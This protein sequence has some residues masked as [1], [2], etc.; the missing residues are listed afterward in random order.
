MVVNSLHEISRKIIT[1]SH[2]LLKLLIVL[3]FL[4][5]FLLYVID[6]SS[7]VVPQ[8]LKIHFPLIGNAPPPD[9]AWNWDFLREYDESVREQ[10]KSYFINTPGC[11]MPKFNVFDAYI[12]A[13]LSKEMSIFCKPPLVS[14]DQHSLWISLNRTEISDIYNVETVDDLNCY[15]Q[16][17]YRKGDSSNEFPDVRY[18]LPFGDLV[19]V[20]DENIRVICTYN[21]VEIYRDYHFFFPDRENLSTVDG[22]LGIVGDHSNST[23]NKYNVMV[24]GLDSVSRLNFHRQMIESADVLLNQLRAIELFGYNKVADNTYPN[25][26]P[27]LAG[28]DEDEMQAACMP[29]KSD[30]FDQCHF[31]WDEYKRRNYTTMFAEDMAWIGLFNYFKNGFTRAPTDYYFRTFIYECETN[32]GTQKESNAYMCLGGR[33]TV[34]VFIEYM[35]KFVAYITEANMSHFSFFWSSAYTHDFFNYP[36]LLDQAFATFLRN[37]SNNRGA[38]DN[39]FLLVMSDHGLRFGSYRNTYQGMMEERQPFLYLIPP[40]NFPAK[41]PVAMRNLV[42]NQRALTTHFDL[43]ETMRDLYDVQSLTSA[44]LKQRIEEM[45]DT[46]PMPRGISLFLP[47]PSNRTCVAAGISPHWCTCHERKDIPKNDPRV[48]DAARK[49]VNTMNEL[50]NG[51]P[52]CQKLSLNSITDAN[53]GTSNKAIN[54][55]TTNSFVD[56]SVRLQTKPGFGEFEAT[57]RVHDNNDMNLTGSI[58]RTN[59]YGEQSNCIDDYHLKLYCFCSPPS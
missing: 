41:Y 57:V 36:A 35:N 56:I 9:D 53:L 47:I 37:L 1:H 6:I 10:H 24:I 7:I 59:L 32:I 38:L 34:D 44:A 17:F 58:S 2:Y 29:N 13:Y 51:R 50:L 40:T 42:M 39:T 3:I 8:A 43:Y 5:G 48:I 19:R 45:H 23:A 55:N 54:K 31:I 4:F 27:V 11:R 18:A 14:S 33:R 49:V 15:Y 20:S 22:N 30:T 52:L 46:D 21:D 28:L 25:L 12:N 26:M 16:A